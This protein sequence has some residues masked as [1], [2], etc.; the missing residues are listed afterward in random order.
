MKKS[1]SLLLHCL[2]LLLL[3]LNISLLGAGLHFAHIIQ[4]V[5]IICILSIII[6]LII[7]INT[8]IIFFRSQ[9]NSEVVRNKTNALQAKDL[10]SF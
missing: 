8:G 1:E 10:L 5:Q 6:T 2:C 3:I 9:K 7:I 4:T